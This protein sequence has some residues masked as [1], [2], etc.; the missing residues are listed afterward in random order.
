MATGDY[1]DAQES[2]ILNNAGTDAARIAMANLGAVVTFCFAVINDSNSTDAAKAECRAI[3]N[4]IAR[5]E[6]NA[7]KYNLL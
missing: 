1:V 5:I 2:I 4:R 3:V 7:E 6:Y